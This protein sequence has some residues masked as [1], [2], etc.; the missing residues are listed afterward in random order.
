MVKSKEL[1]TIDG[2]TGEVMVGEVATIKPEL[3]KHFS[4]LMGWADDRRTL[5]VRSNAETPLDVS[6]AREFG[7]EGIGLCRTEH[8]FFDA[9]RI[10]D[11]RQM[12]MSILK[13][14]EKMP[15]LNYCQFKEMFLLHSLLLCE[16]SL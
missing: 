11:V 8:M 10:I 1:I 4:E 2:G 13:R 12:I 15:F 5:Q 6:A 7:A 16:A 14:L 3:G 9:S